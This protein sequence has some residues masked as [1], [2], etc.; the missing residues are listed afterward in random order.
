MA[1]VL[2]QRGTWSLR[3]REE[4]MPRMFSNTVLRKIFE[5]KVEK[6]TGGWSEL[7]SV[8]FYYFYLP[9]VIRLNKPSRMWHA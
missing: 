6:V 8:T 1:V 7:R 9:D 5:S 2:C 3:E 4:R